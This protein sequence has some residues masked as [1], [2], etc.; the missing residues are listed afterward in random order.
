MVRNEN[1]VAIWLTVPRYL[2]YY[3][4]LDIDQARWFLEDGGGGIIVKPKQIEDRWLTRRY[5]RPHKLY[6]HHFWHQGTCDDPQKCA[7]ISAIT[8]TNAV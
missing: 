8:L 2:P 6:C 5:T 3:E 4:L 1:N 7:R